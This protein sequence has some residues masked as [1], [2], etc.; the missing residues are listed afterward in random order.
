MAGLTPEEQAFFE[1]GGDASKLAPEPAAADP[2]ANSGLG[3][4]DPAPAA[5]QVATPVASVETPHVP[6]PDPSDLLRTTL[7]QTQQQAADLRAELEA[8]RTANV[9]KP[10]AAPDPNSDPL[11]N[12][13][14][15]LDQVNKN[16]ADLQAKLLDQ[17]T[18]QQQ[19]AAFQRF[20]A[21][22]QNL[23]D[24][25]VKTTPDFQAAYDH[26]RSVRAADL[27]S[28]GI[29]EDNIAKQIFTEEFN[30]SQNAIGAAKN[31]A[32]ELYEMAKRHGY[33]PT[34]ATSAP[35]VDRSAEK[36]AALKAGVAASPPSLPKTHIA[37]DFTLES[38]RDA[39][40]SDL[41]KLITD[42]AAWAKIAGKDHIPI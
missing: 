18:Q 11:G 13:L 42:P 15:Q 25:F 1:S 34:A 23:R 7:A 35:V 26:M 41:N 5:L 10:V 12:M 2:V 9:P 39:S 17:Q 37:E 31:P 21:Q 27:R 32:A 19:N 29:S 36:I 33:K 8:I 3:N 40:E 14:H 24:D 30:L 22:V 20:Q 16:V 6:Q 28:Y 38:L 4:S